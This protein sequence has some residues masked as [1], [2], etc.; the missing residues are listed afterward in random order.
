MPRNYNKLIGKIVEVF[1]TRAVFAQHMSGCTAT[2][3]NPNEGAAGAHG[4]RLPWPTAHR[5]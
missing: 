3:R 5:H 4:A 2:R 1:G